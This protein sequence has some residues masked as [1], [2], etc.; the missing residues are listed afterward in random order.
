MVT[1]T[2]STAYDDNPFAFH[3][4]T[5]HEQI[6]TAKVKRR[7][8]LPL[9]VD[10]VIILLIVGAAG[11]VGYVLTHPSVYRSPDA[12]A[13]D[14]AHQMGSGDYQNASKD[15]DPKEQASALSL[16]RSE[17]QQVLNGDFIGVH[18]T[19]VASSQVTGTTAS[20]ELKSC[21]A[22][23][24]CNPLPTIPCEETDGKWYVDWGLMVD[25]TS[26]S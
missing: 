10:A 8:H 19:Q 5:R 2:K 6:T 25:T 23:L 4:Q 21:N 12:I 18:T 7:G 11:A 16:L 3:K 14:F 13:V 22:S 9:W 24:A 1:K 20:V 15:V 26:S 17:G